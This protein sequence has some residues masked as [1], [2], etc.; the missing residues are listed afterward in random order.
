M[1]VNP[2]VATLC[3]A[4]AGCGDDGG[5]PDP[6]GGPGADVASETNADMT[7]P[8]DV[9]SSACEAGTTECGQFCCAD[10]EY[11]CPPAGPLAATCAPTSLDCP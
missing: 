9:V 10:S 2:L 3:F 8:S 6:D 7:G 4:L 1:R 5:G 11:C